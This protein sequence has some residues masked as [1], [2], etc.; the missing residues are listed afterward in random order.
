LQLLDE[1]AETTKQSLLATLSNL[2]QP[3]R[4]RDGLDKC[5]SLEK[6]QRE[7][8]GDRKRGGK[9]PKNK[10]SRDLRDLQ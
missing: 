5:M 4:F 2:L 8:G 7:V 9:T 6:S 10:E 1:N 3:Y